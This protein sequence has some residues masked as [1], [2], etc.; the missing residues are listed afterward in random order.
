MRL[1]AQ[2]NAGVLLSKRPR[3]FGRARLMLAGLLISGPLN[4]PAQPNVIVI[5][6]DDVSARSY[7]LYGAET[8][9]EWGVVSPVVET[10]ATEG[11]YFDTAWCIPRC[12]PTRALLHTGKYPFRTRV[13]G[14]QIYPRGGGWSN[15]AD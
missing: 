10:M 3:L 5:L 2:F 13:F 11:M 8:S 14:Q 1:L 15:Q 12:T 7:A 9:G 4:A 6:A